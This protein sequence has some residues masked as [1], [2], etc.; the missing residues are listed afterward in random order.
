MTSIPASILHISQSD[1]SGG[2]A[3]SAHKIHTGLQTLGM[4]SRMMV[5]LRLGEDQENVGL[6]QQ[7]RSLKEL[8]RVGRRIVDAIGLQYLYYPS[9]FA[10]L[11]N[12]WLKTADIV[13]LY[14]LHG[15]YF[16]HRILPRLS[17]DRIVV[18]RLSDMWPLTGHCSY[19]FDCERWKTGCGK[20]PRLDEYPALHWD[21]TALLWRIK[22]SIY[23]RSRIVIVATNRWMEQVARE[24]PLI[25]HF[26]IHVIPNGVDTEVFQ[27]TPKMAAREQ[28]KLPADAK[29]V[30]FT[31]KV[32]RPG[33]RKGGQFVVPTM[34]Q[35]A[36]KGLDKLWL[37]VMGEEAESWPED[38]AYQTLRIKYGRNDKDL[39]KVYSAADM[40]IYPAL[41]ENLPNGIV[42]SMACGTPAVAFPIGGV[43]DLVRPGETGYLAAGKDVDSLV[44]ALYPILNNTDLLNKMGARCREVAL[45]EFTLTIQ[46]RRFF[47]LYE[48]LISDAF[49]R[50]SRLKPNTWVKSNAGLL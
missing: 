16:T 28:L 26:P 40:L 1:I 7:S 19:S 30:L 42:E 32:A 22:K 12:A 35:L 3:R 47:E 21:T 27:P 37:V 34:Q 46:T 10:L 38:S 2:S 20:C 45:Q 36:A 31:A 41:A 9:S 11:D 44:A 43:P 48:S 49:T 4:Q 24:S 15:G 23:A 39:A 6:I 13:Q 25:G 5:Q 50:Q 18:W 8:D 17:Q 33:T 29:I 14:N